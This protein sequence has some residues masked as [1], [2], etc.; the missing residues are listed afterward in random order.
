MTTL[1]LLQFQMLT[2]VLIFIF[3]LY[4]FIY[5]S[6]FYNLLTVLYMFLC[7]ALKALHLKSSCCCQ[8]PL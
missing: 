1:R 3:V 5:V 7:D 8:V 2:L 4:V 6:V